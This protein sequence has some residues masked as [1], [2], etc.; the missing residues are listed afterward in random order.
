MAQIIVGDKSTIRDY[1]FETK[2]TTWEI[3]LSHT[4]HSWRGGHNCCAGTAGT[5]CR[6]SEK[7]GFLSLRYRKQPIDIVELKKTLA[8]EKVL[9]QTLRYANWI[10]NNPDTVRYQIKKQGLNLNA[11]E[12]DTDSIKVVIIAP[13]VSQVLRSC[14]ST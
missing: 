14:V 6:W 2:C 11:E 4:G 12:V 3:L 13:K 9:L 8:D 7:D 1:P 5:D 10:R